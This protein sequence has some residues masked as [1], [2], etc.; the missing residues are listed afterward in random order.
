MTRQKLWTR[1][2]AIIT[3]ELFLISMNFYLLM[4]VVSKFATERFG[5]STAL[6]GFAASIF[7]IG[8]LVTRPLSGKWIHPVGQTRTLYA[9][10]LMSLVMTLLYFAVNSTAVLLLIRFLHGAAFG[11]TTVATGTIVAGVVPRERYGEGI[12]YF[13]LGSTMA[14]AIG[15]FIGLFLIQHHGFNSVIIAC[16]IASA[17]GVVMLPLLSVGELELTEEQVKDA[18]G[19]KLS[20]LIEPRVVPI[21]LTL[22]ITYLCYASVVS[23]LALYSEEI[24]LTGAASLFFIVFALAIFVTRP[25]VGRRFDVKGENSV[26]YPAFLIFAASLA[27]FSQARLGYVLLLAA[28][29]MGLGFGALQS[30]GQAITVKITSQHRM[31][32]AASTRLMFL[33]MGFGVGP[34]LWGIV[35]PFAGYRGMY[36]AVA[37]VA[38][39]CLLLYY[40]LYG[41][42]VGG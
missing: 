40:A 30:S 6:A 12:G 35:I 7:V 41:R 14:V 28:A 3:L 10:A 27:I 23:F 31:G 4:T 16:S 20:N 39:G 19:F 5:T 33:D 22:L 21:S 13:T 17:I 29:A 15:P 18:K 2:F 37:I 11:V 1:S 32:L 24:R 8:G 36:V 42:H 26:M 25:F 38:A 9:G 34:L